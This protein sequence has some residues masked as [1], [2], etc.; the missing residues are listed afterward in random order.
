MTKNE[1]KLISVIQTICD[2]I[3]DNPCGCDACPYSE[4]EEQCEVHNL[5][6]EIEAGGTDAGN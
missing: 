4:Y 6:E 1:E 3:L 2:A 5:I